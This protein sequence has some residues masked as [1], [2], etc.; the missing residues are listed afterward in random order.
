MCLDCEKC[1]HVFIGMLSAIKFNTDQMQ[2]S[3]LSG[4]ANA[5]DAVI[6]WLKGAP[7]PKC[8]KSLQDGAAAFCKQYCLV[9]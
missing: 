7:L 4:F 8:L 2:R 9:V 3:V 6:T 1:I 5:T